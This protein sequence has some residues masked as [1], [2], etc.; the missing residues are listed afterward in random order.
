MSPDT[1]SI[2]TG[3]TSTPTG[4]GLSPAPFGDDDPRMAFAR[5]VSTARNVIGA[6]EPDQ[7]DRPTPCDAFSVRD[8][9]GHLTAVLRR[10]AVIG[11]GGSPFEVPD[12]VSDVDD[13]RWAE[14][15]TAA[16]HEVQRVWT[17]DALDRS[18]QVPWRTMSGREAL[19]VYTCEVT[20]HTWDLARATG[21]RVAWDPLAVGA[22]EAAIRRELAD[23]GRH[24][25]FEAARAAMPTDAADWPD[26]FLA[27]V[28]VADDAPAIDRLVAFN[29][30]RPEWAAP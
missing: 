15:W 29:G 18:V 3:T 22:G 4:T 6:V 30:R 2:T 8:L 23:E 10:V 20:V 11:T 25:M 24:E 16:A 21:Q 27:A 9:L 5:A 28:P 12:Q 17:D 13:E 7:L 19:G 14:A 26:P 1:T